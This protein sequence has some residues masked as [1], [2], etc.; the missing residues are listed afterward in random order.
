[1]LHYKPQTAT[2]TPKEAVKTG[3]KITGYTAG[4]TFS[5]GG[6]LVEQE[7]GMIAAEWGLELKFPAYWMC[8]VADGELIEVGDKLLVDGMTYYVKAGPMKEQ[9][10]PITSY[11]YLIVARDA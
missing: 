4:S 10:E 5:V 11:A 8:D 2:V 1:M 3:R 6:M 9:A 7:P